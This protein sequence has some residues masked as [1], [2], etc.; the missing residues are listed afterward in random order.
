VAAIVRLPDRMRG[1][2]APQ[3]HHLKIEPAAPEIHDEED[4]SFSVL[5]RFLHL[6]VYLPLNERIV[7]IRLLAGER[8]SGIA[9]YLGLSR[10]AIHQRY[11]KMLDRLRVLWD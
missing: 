8:V 1:Q 10:Q 2:Q 4:N 6:S 3:V 9:R 5:H 11:R 7:L